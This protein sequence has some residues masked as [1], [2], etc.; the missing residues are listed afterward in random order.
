MTAATCH[1]CGV[2][3]P[4]SKGGPPR[5]WCGD[6]C[7][8]HTLYGGACVDCGATTNGGNGHAVPAERCGACSGTA[9]A[10]AARAGLRDTR[11]RAVEALWFAGLTMR[12]IA[13]T[14]DTTEPTV[15]SWLHRMRRDGWDVPYRRPH[16]ASPAE[17]HRAARTRTPSRLREPGVCQRDPSA[18]RD[19]RAAHGVA[20]PHAL[21]QR[22]PV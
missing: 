9:A 22:A 2:A 1:G 17:R 16:L 10:N 4:P 15:K 13:A 7:R 11:Y 8:K 19:P 6:R 20:R 14:L 5:K 21:R 18:A 3:L 12:G